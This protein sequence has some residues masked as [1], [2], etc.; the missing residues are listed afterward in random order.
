[1]VIRVSKP[2]FNLRDK[3]SELDYDRVPYQKIPTGGVIQI[4]QFTSDEQ[5]LTGGAATAKINS[6]FTPKISG[7]KFY[8]SVFVP[9]CTSGDGER[10]IGQVYLGTNDTPSENTKIIQFRQRMFGTSADDT[11]C[12]YAHDF[13]GFTCSTTETHYASLVLTPSQNTVVARHSS[14]ANDGFIKLVVQEIAQ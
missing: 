9:N 3:I 13:G 2:E 4:V 10:L 14:N 1:M 8:V 7:S 6:T 5:S 11:V 12:I